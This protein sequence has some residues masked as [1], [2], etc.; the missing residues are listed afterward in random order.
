MTLQKISVNDDIRNSISQGHVAYVINT[1]DVTAE[2]E[3]NDGVAIRLLAIENDT[4]IFTSLDTV[5]ALLDV[6]E[7]ITLKVSVIN[8]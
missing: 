2:D 8:A 7:E 1:R 6:L 4:N 3:L 5:K